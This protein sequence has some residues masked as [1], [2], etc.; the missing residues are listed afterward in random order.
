MGMR[1]ALRLLAT[2]VAA[3]LLVACGDDDEPLATGDG[4]TTPSG[5]A[6]AE[7][8]LSVEVS[9][10]GTAR[11]LVDGTTITLRFEGG[12]L[13]ASLGCNQLGAPYEIDGDRL[14]V[15]EISTT[16]MGCDAE[17]HAQDQWFAELLQSGPAITVDGD[18]LTLT[19]DGTAVVLVDR[20][21]AEPDAALVGTTWE[22][23]GFADGQDPEDS[24]M[25]FGVEEP[26][27]VR[28]EGN[29][30]ITGRDG[31]NG[32]GY[33]ESPGEPTEGRRY[34]ASGDR[35]VFGGER[36]TELQACPDLAEY[37]ERFWAALTGT[38]TWA[39]DADTL[40]LVG[41]DGR[42]MT[43]RAAE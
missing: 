20:E 21:V 17:R 30:F 22:V 32:F 6:L 35:L 41:E 31:C 43:L 10:D 37:T 4:T 9:E 18:R 24:A 19:A 23:D 29:G 25:S 16:A 27:I 40:T 26:G 11:P 2:L 42:S 39:I 13:G 8:Y 15:Q 38:V 14:V 36:V 5:A 12:R 33:A 3:V 7:E 34:E 28:F 1:S